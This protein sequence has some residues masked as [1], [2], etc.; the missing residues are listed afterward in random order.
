[1]GDSTSRAVTGGGALFLCSVRRKSVGGCGDGKEG[2]REHARLGGLSGQATEELAAAIE[3]KQHARN[4][5]R[6]HV[7]GPRRVAHIWREKGGARRLEVPLEK[8]C[9][10][11]SSSAHA[12]RNRMLSCGPSIITSSAVMSARAVGVTPCERSACAATWESGM[13]CPQLPSAGGR[14]MDSM[15]NTILESMSL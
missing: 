13:T 7:A 15:R 9:P 4:I 2:P 11:V 3:R 8:Y 10:H 14:I 5:K 12:Q 6:V 1:M